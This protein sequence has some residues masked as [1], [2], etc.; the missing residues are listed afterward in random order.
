MGQRG[1]SLAFCVEVTMI[2]RKC[3]CGSAERW[4]SGETVHPCQ[5][6]KK[7]QTTFASSP[8]N[9]KAL[10]THDWKPRYNSE[11]GELDKR[12]CGRCYAIERVS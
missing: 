4:D 12:M 11:T 5:G 7:C 10:E 6:C 1:N 2:Y 8:D 9:H 3:K